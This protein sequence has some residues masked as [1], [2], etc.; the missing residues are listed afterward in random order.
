MSRHHFLPKS[1]GG[2]ATERICLACHD[3]IHLLF[4]NKQ[5]E[6]EDLTTIEALKADPGMQT[7]LSWV[8]KRNPDR[9]FKG[10]RSH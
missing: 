1:R 6:K 8:E 5:I 9:R 3:Q 2:T 7:Y 10:R 4:T